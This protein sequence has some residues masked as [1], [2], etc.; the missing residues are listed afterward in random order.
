MLSSGLRTFLKDVARTVAE[1]I[2]RVGHMAF[3]GTYFSNRFPS[4]PRVHTGA[5]LKDVSRST[6]WLAR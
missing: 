2:G 3:F 1:S 4:Q 5:F 6:V